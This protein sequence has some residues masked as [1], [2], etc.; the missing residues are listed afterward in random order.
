MPPPPNSPLY[1]VSNTSLYLVPLSPWIFHPK[2]FIRSFRN[3]RLL[4]ALL[5]E[6][7]VEETSVCFLSIRIRVYMQIDG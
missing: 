5:K 3:N 4:L 2:E 7:E 1:L 6:R